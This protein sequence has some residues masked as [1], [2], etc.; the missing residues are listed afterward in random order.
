[1]K[2]FLFPLSF[3]VLLSVSAVAFSPS[4]VFADDDNTDEVADTKGDLKE[5][6][7]DLE[8]AEK[9]RDALAAEA[10]SI[11]SSISVVNRAINQTQSVI[12]E[13]EET[14]NRKEA[15]IRK[16]EE[17]ADRNRSILGRLLLEAYYQDAEFALPEILSE[18]DMLRALNEPGQL[19][20]MGNRIREILDNIQALRSAITDEKAELEDVKEE[21]EKLLDM[22]EA[23]KNELAREHAETRSD[24]AQQEATVGEL[25]AK[26]VE[27]QSDLAVLTGKAYDAKDIREAVEFASKKTDVPKGV[28]YGFLK[29]ETNLG[30]NT[31]QCTYKQVKKDAIDLWYGSSSKWKASRDLLEKRMDL[32]YDLVDDLD[33]SKN[34]K[35]SCTPRSYRGQGGAMGVSQFMSDVW[36]GYKSQVAAATG[37]K[38]PDPW[39]LTDGVMAMALKLEKAG[40]TSS[41]ESV[42]KQASINYLGAFNSGYYNGIVY[43]SKNYKKLFD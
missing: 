24:L 28:L 10:A 38:T 33:Y 11:A 1:M 2:A 17:D 20:S 3:V 5:V 15:E 14:I 36:N 30:A 22:K 9:E 35:V 41:K 32:F 39:N 7:K 25:R 29:M 4:A 13:T 18:E 12:E 31:G 23:Q 21:K 34:K 19:R 43:W 40:A 8:K 16:L 6:E 42:I 37:H 27:L 26:L